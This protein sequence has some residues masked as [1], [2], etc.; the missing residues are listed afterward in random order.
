MLCIYPLK[1]NK[2]H[3]FLQNDGQSILQKFAKKIAL[4]F[5]TLIRTEPKN[6][7]KKFAILKFAIL[8]DHHFGE[9]YDAF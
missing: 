8:T 3:F 9:K 7:K 5:C 1:I 6:C 4:F 2:L